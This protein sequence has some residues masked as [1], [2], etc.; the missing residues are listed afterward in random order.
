MTQF[1]PPIL[2]NETMEASIRNYLRAKIKE[3]EQAKKEIEAN[4][5]GYKG[6]LEFFEKHTKICK[7]CN[8]T[9]IIQYLVSETAYVTDLSASTGVSIP[10]PKCCPKDSP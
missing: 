7:R 9:K 6:L 2:I 5:K 8:D 4:T 3:L 10:C 1:Y